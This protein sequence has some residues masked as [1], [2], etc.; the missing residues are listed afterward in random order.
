[1]L[2]AL[3]TTFMLALP[4]LF[5][6]WFRPQP[7]AAVDRARVRRLRALLWLATAAGLGI[8]FGLRAMRAAGWLDWWKQ[9]PRLFTWSD[10]PDEIAWLLFFPL[11][12]AIAMPLLAAVRPSSTSPYPET[13]TR[14][15]SLRPRTLSRPIRRAHWLAGWTIWAAS[16]VAVGVALGSGR[17]AALAAVLIPLGVLPVALGPLAVRMALRE[18]EPLDSG[19]S[20]ELAGSYARHR[21]AK[22]WGLFWLLTA[23]T[24]LGSLLPAAVAWRL[25][26]GLAFAVG[27]S[28]VGLFGAAFGVHMGLQRMRIRERLDELE[29][30][31]Q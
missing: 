19:G 23:L 2:R 12:F 26:L 29:R 28:L 14:S 8:Y 9:I 11:W 20:E 7:G 27:G 15:A 1:M 13:A 6:L 31:P 30:R 22:A 17:G 16:A 10:G 4:A 21:E 18:P 3:F 5:M 24:A 25:P